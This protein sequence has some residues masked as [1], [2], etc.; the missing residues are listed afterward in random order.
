MRSYPKPR[1][2]YKRDGALRAIIE[3]PKGSPNKY[4]YD[5]NCD[6]FELA[7]TLPEGMAFP[8]DF[9]FIPSTTGEDGDP[10]DVL[11]LMDS[12]VFPGC[13]L[14]VRLIGCIQAD[15]KEDGEK[16]IRND[17]LIAI[18]EHARTHS[19]VKTLKELRPHLLD[20]IK[21]FFVQYNKLHDKKFRLLNNTAQ[22]RRAAVNP[23]MVSPQRQMVIARSTATFQDCCRLDVPPISYLR[24][25]D[26][27]APNRPPR[28][29]RAQAPAHSAA[30]SSSKALNR[31]IVGAI[32]AARGQSDVV[33][34]ASG[35]S[36]APLSDLSQEARRRNRSAQ[37]PVSPLRADTRFL[38]SPV[39]PVA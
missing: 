19:G 2:S 20:E 3:T 34:R 23:D 39:A 11:V 30:A 6:C 5:P 18:A 13:M 32:P 26:R 37:V 24:A 7:T 38:G 16:W 31:P 15:E 29:H 9:G 33:R 10:L 17:P 27:L 35:G 14:R 28:L 36:Q 4:D 25:K 1:P 12:P 21:A 22:C 8:F